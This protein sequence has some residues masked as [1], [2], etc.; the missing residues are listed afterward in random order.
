M[1]DLKKILVGTV[2]MKANENGTPQMLVVMKDRVYPTLDLDEF[3]AK[4]G[5][6]L[7]NN[8]LEDFEPVAIVLNPEG[9]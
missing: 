9:T 6:D 3:K 2:Y 7:S 1:P 4:F 5:V 8:N